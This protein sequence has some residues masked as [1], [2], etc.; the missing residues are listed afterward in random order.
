M[1]KGEGKSLILPA[2]GRAQSQS[3]RKQDSTEGASMVSWLRKAAAEV[4]QVMVSGS[5]A[6]A[7]V[8]KSP[9]FFVDLTPAANHLSFRE[10]SGVEGKEG[11]ESK[12]GK[13]A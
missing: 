6:I 10:E 9:L 7:L 11:C 2:F 3:E 1:R 13:Q 5:Q 12:Q 4:R 8:R